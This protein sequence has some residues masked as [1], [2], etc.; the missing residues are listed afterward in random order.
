M[1][2]IL[3]VDDEDEVRAAVKRRLEREGYEVVTAASAAEASALFDK[4][5]PSFDLVVTDMSMEETNSGLEVLQE[6]VAHDIFTEVIVLT[7]YGNVAN[8]VESMRRGAFDYLEK[9][10]PG[11]DVYELLIM[12]VSQAMDR[13]RAAVSTV[14]RLEG[15]AA[16]RGS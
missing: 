11:I 12:K 15:A 6:A 14:R 8:A 7:A 3:V 10:T 16:R 2:R 4:Q 9:N 13:R 5:G 1:A